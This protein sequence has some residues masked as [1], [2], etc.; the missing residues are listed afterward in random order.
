MKRALNRIGKRVVFFLMVLFG[1][2]T[3]P[4]I[5]SN[6]PSPADYQ[7]ACNNLRAIGC[8]DGAV[9]WCPVIL[10]KM[11]DGHLTNVDVGC[12]MTAKDSPAAITCGGV[13]CR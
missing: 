7:D 3:T 9:D 10:Q 12:L 1:C 13:R 8:S 2:A 11:V 5:P 4:P 6:P